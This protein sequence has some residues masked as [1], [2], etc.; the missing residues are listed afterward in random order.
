MFRDIDTERI[1]ELNKEDYAPVGCN[2]C[3]GC[4]SC[5]T[6]TAVMIVLDEFDMKLLKEG[7]NYS[8]EGMLQQGMIQ[9]QVVDGIV[10]PGLGT[11]ENGACV[12][13]REDGRCSIHRYRP[14]ICRMF[15][16]AR[17]YHEDGSFS[18]FLQEGEC[19]RRTGEKI[20]IADWIGYKDMDA[21]EKAV[22]EYHDS[23]SLLREYCAESSSPQEITQL[24]TEFLRKHFF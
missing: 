21:Y 22:Q 15:P 10:L 9:L 2:D 5:C 1:V 24:Q 4:S 11:D 6:D 3:A 16:L 18:Y 12:F 17:I 19:D 8:F 23:L 14:G 20:R 13:L 7:L